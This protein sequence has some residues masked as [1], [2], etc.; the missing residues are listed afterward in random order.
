MSQVYCKQFYS[1]Q[2]LCITILF[3]LK[4]F[5][6]INPN[7]HISIHCYVILYAIEDIY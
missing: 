4:Q 3:S 6:L 5:I 2:T 7:K 1:L